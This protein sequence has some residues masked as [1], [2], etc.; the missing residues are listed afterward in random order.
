MKK[1]TLLLIFILLI[2]VSGVLYYFLFWNKDAAILQTLQSFLPFGPSA[3]ENGQPE[4]QQTN[5]DDANI[6][7]EINLANAPVP[8]FRRVSERPVAGYTTFEQE[9]IT[10]V[11]GKKYKKTETVIRFI[12]QETG[13]I[14]DTKTTSLLTERVARTTFSKIF[15][16]WFTNKGKNVI[17]RFI[18]DNFE[19]RSFVG[20]IMAKTST[21]TLAEGS[22]IGGYDN[23]VQEFISVS[24]DTSSIYGEGASAGAGV[25]VV[26]AGNASGPK[27]VFSSP[28]SEWLPQWFGSS[29]VAITTKAS[30]GVPGSLFYINTKNGSQE[31]VLGN[32][33][34]LTTLVSPSGKAILYSESGKGGNFALNLY[35]KNASATLSVDKATL[36]EKCVWNKTESIVYCLIPSQLE[37]PLPDQWYQGVTHF[38]DSIWRVDPSTG[39]TYYEFDPSQQGGVDIDGVRPTL[40]PDGRYLLFMNKKDNTLWALQIDFTAPPE[41][42]LVK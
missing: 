12:D 3:A 8:L 24:P 11:D 22:I 33:Q 42:V 40:T 13:N 17:M 35:K 2:I 9:T 6:P 1:R 26:S 28:F 15:D 34:G 18:N 41:P 37:S 30:A 29:T 36:P 16:A 5:T 32:I 39:N 10:I 19:R 14:F 27:V 25:G 4:P 21:S 23:S 31:K 7:V 20:T 38:T